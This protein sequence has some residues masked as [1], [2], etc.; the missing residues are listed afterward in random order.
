MVFVY[1]NP[2]TGRFQVRVY[3]PLGK[4]LTVV[5]Y[6]ANVQ[7]VYRKAMVTSSPY[8]RMDVDLRNVAGGE[9]N[10]VVVDGDG[11]IIGSSQIM[12]VR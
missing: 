1:P 11:I 4:Q 6:K 12:I 3:N 9:Y 7:L 2:S 5:V 10:I 8:T